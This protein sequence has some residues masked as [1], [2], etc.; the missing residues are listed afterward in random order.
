MDTPNPS[1]AR[2]RPKARTSQEIIQGANGATLGATRT[3]A[4]TQ[5]VIAPA[6]GTRQ[7]QR[8]PVVSG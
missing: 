4:T 2:I 8:G 5:R 7:A 1:D 3:A 6:N